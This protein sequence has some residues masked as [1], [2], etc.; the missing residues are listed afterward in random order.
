MV[1]CPRGGGDVAVLRTVVLTPSVRGAR[2]GEDVLSS[3]EFM[4]EAFVRLLRGG[5]VSRGGP[6]GRS[7]PLGT[8]V[9]GV[10]F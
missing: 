10:G 9:G 8:R 7:V 2:V 3:C 1:L 6:S 4:R 5:E